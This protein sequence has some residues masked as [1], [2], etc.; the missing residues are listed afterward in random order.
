MGFVF[1][2]RNDSQ[3]A[4]HVLCAD[5]ARHRLFEIDQMPVDAASDLE[6]LGGRSNHKRPPIL[7]AD[8]ACDETARGEPIEDAR[9]SRTFVR[10]AAMKFGDRRGR[11]RGEQRQDVP[12][13]LR[14]A[15]VTQIGQIEAD[16]VRRSVNGRD[17]AQ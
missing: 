14:Q 15:V 11:R 4:L 8:L 10:Q 6:T 2:R 16:P 17:E 5:A 3:K 9:Q 7:R 12:F 13:A 1:D